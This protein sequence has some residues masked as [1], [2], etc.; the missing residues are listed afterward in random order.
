MNGL[1][2]GLGLGGR[3]GGGGSAPWTPAAFGAASMPLWLRGDSM[4]T[5]VLTDKSGNGNDVAAVAAGVL[6]TLGGQPAINLAGGKNYANTVSSLVAAGSIYTVLAVAKAADAAG[7]ALLCLRRSAPASDSAII[8]GT[9][10]YS[11][12][13]TVNLSLTASVATEAQSPFLAEW[14]MGGA[15]VAGAFRMNRT[16]RATDGHLQA[17]ESGT[18]GFLIGTDAFGNNFNGILAEKIVLNRALVGG[19]RASWEAYVLDRYGF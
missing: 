11:D 8:S 17:T 5:G 3:G 14:S 18:A 7:G 12:L 16:A 9:L 4:T 10:I 19:E 15:G 2:L 6:T 13:A 1:G